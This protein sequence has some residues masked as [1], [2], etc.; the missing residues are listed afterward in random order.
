MELRVHAHPGASRTKVA[1]PHEPSIDVD[2]CVWIS[3]R[4][5]EGAAN[6]ALCTA[7]AAAL[8]VRSSAVTLRSGARSRYK[9]LEVPDGVT[10]PA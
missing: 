5:V 3:A 9:V 1:I 6:V 2:A 10:L 4:A 8:G 7:V